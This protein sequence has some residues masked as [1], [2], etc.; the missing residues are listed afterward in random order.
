MKKNQQQATSV[1][2]LIRG[3]QNLKP[4]RR[5]IGG[6]VKTEMFINAI[7]RLYTQSKGLE[8]IERLK[9]DFSVGRYKDGWKDITIT[10]KIISLALALYV[11]SKIS[12]AQLVFFCSFQ[13][14][15]IFDDRWMNKKIPELNDIQ[16]LMNELHNDGKRWTKRKKDKYDILQNKYDEEIENQ[17]IRIFE[18]LELKN[19]AHARKSH[20]IEFEKMRERG[21]RTIF[22]KDDTISALKD[23]VL[24]YEEEARKAAAAQAYAAAIVA[25]GSGLEGLLILRCMK[26]K[27]K[28]ILVASKLTG[29]Q[30]PSKRTSDDP[31]MWTFDTLIQTCTNAGW[32]KSSFTETMKLK[33]DKMAHAIRIMRNNVHPGKIARERPWREIDEEEY[34]DAEAIYITLLTQVLKS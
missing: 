5:R 23:I 10:R 4:L 14:E 18:E 19:L 31:T 1:L 25:L 33:T 22:H 16:A 20:P 8:A 7:D 6:S 32:M 30:K 3:K 15:D 24:Y 9:S 27:K 17:F 28:A 13:V 21:R 34:L 29:L 12:E 26:S 2:H 11:A